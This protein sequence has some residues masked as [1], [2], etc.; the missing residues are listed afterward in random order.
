MPKR[1]K[2]SLSSPEK[3]AVAFV[4]GYSRV[5]VTAEEFVACWSDES[6]KP[7][8]IAKVKELVEAYFENIDIDEYAYTHIQAVLDDLEA[9]SA[10][11]RWVRD[12]K[13]KDTLTDYLDL[14]DE[15]DKKQRAILY[16]N[17]ESYDTENWFG[18]LQTAFKA[19]SEL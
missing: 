7:E 14:T 12:S 1:T 17:D 9:M 16:Q 10:V 3:D 15:E 18:S 2:T 13:Y 4:R 19:M 8:T 6:V 5:G 11:Y